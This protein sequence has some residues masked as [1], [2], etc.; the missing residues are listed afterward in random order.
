MGAR[1]PVRAWWA[2]PSPLPSLWGH[3]WRTKAWGSTG[4]PPPTHPSHPQPHAPCPGAKYRSI[5]RD[6]KGSHHSPNR[7]VNIFR[8]SPCYSPSPPLK[9]AIPVT[10]A[11][12]ASPRLG[13]KL[14][15][16]PHAGG[17]LPRQS[18]AA[19]LKHPQLLHLGLVF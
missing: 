6:F 8:R 5:R 14:T 17:R 15:V 10:Q 12:R 3:G 9:H 7:W 19:V 2:A 11:T 1:E 18:L 4:S 13:A 16:P